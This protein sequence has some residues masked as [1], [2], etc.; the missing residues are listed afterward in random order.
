MSPTRP[1]FGEGGTPRQFTPVESLEHPDGGPSEGSS[2]AASETSSTGPSQSSAAGAAAAVQNELDN[3]DCEN[4]P[5]MTVE[6]E[7][8]ALGLQSDGRPLDPGEAQSDAIGNAA[9]GAVVGGILGAGEALAAGE[10]AIAHSAI[11]GAATHVVGDVVGDAAEAAA[12]TVGKVL[13]SSGTQTEGGDTTGTG[14]TSGSGPTTNTGEN[15]SGR[16][17]SDSPSDGSGSSDPS[18]TSGH[19]ASSSSDEASSSQPSDEHGS[20]GHEGGGS[21]GGDVSPGCFATGTLV[22]TG[23]GTFRPIE[24]LRPGDTVMSAAE[25][26]GPAESRSV[27]RTWTHSDRP[28]IE[29]GFGDGE[30]ILATSV[31]LVFTTEHGLVP[32]S[33]LRVGDHLRGVRSD[34]VVTRVELAD[35]TRTVH[36]ISVDDLHTFFV[37]RSGAWVHN[38]KMEGDPLGQ[39]D[40]EGD[41]S[42]DDKP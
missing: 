30:S 9:T 31:H 33:A 10:D 36:N 14:E 15:T 35:D 4:D 7:N 19:P 21:E 22:A 2:S 20:S 3:Q 11:A 38:E 25:S 37:G 27:V 28:V 29:I 23:N 39:E 24:D 13:S 6:N 41:D 17:A 16:S 26:G 8:A 18:Q 42:P 5:Q 1:E 40:D 12:E 32:V 34:I